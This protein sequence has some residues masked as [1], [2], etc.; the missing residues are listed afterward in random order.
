MQL[1]ELITGT[2]VK[3]NN[4]SLCIKGGWFEAIKRKSRLI[5]DD[6]CTLEFCADLLRTKEHPFLIDIGA[7]VGVFTL[8][9]KS[10]PQLKCCAFEPLVSMIIILRDNI[11][12][13]NI[14]KQVVV[15]NYA[16][17]D[18]LETKILKTP[19]IKSW[20][21]LST[22]GEPKRFNHWFRASVKVITLDTFLD[23]KNTIPS[24][25]KIDVEGNELA[26]LHGAKNLINTHKP[27][28]ICECTNKNTQ[29][30]EYD[31]SEIINLL[32]SWGYEH[33]Q[34]SNDDFY[35]NYMKKNDL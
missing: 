34:I 2:V 18:K 10:I 8:L 26:V 15:F 27:D 24:I 20:A 25:I 5:P 11:K 22:L 7:N 17:G 35:F 29:Q 32:A 21:G 3:V 9:C 19:L 28:I 1:V 23:V 6:F 16:V 12:L 31:C 14:E 4:E 30:F 33:K 13:N